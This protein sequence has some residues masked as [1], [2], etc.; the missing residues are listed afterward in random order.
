MHYDRSTQHP[1]GVHLSSFGMVWFCSHITG[2]Q[3]G[4]QQ[5]LSCQ[6]FFHFP[7]TAAWMLVSQ[8]GECQMAASGSKLLFPI[9]YRF[10]ILP[11]I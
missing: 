2:T 8:L 10:P 7:E 6:E 3:P 4:L 1:H 11:G 5:K 9:I